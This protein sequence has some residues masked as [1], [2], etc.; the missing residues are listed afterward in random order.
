[1]QGQFTAPHAAE[2]AVRLDRIPHS[3][4]APDTASIRQVRQPALVVGAP[5][6]PVHPLGL[7]EATA[8]ALPD[9]TLRVVMERDGDPPRQLAQIAQE[10][11]RFVTRVG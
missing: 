5:R 10:T 4:P 2:R 3:A 1:L 8:A 7:A 11:A 6:D 9:A